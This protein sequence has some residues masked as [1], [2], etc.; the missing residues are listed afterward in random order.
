MARY[1]D[2]DL[3]FKAHPV[4][5]DI[6]TLTD[7]EALKRSVRNLI[8][9][10]RY[11]RPFR[12]ELDAGVHQYLFELATP[13]TAIK[14]KNKIEET[15][16]RD[17]PRVELLDVVGN[18]RTL[19]FVS[20]SGWG[21]FDDLYVKLLSTFSKSYLFIFSATSLYN[22]TFCNPRYDCNL[23]KFSYVSEHGSNPIYFLPDATE[24]NIRPPQPAQG[25]STELPL[26]ASHIIFARCGLN[27]VFL[28]RPQQK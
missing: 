25:S 17:E 13:V 15:I 16:R 23:F 14:I 18:I 12:P 21:R 20:A 7:M 1:S 6:V 5:G 10:K 19:G 9:T 2:I 3:D 28:V 24:P 4:S 8:L 11:D 26:D 22:V 27:I